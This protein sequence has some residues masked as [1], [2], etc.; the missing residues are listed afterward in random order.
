MGHTVTINGA[1]DDLIEVLGDAPGCDEYNADDAVFVL[2]GDHGFSARVRV[3]FVDGVWEIGVGQL[4]ETSP[5]LPMR[6]DSVGYTTRATIENVAIVTR[7][8]A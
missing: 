2:V 8:M 3:A 5:L 1:S 6:L 7:E 4:D